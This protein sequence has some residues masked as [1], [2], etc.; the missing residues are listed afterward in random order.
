LRAGTSNSALIVTKGEIGGRL[1]FGAAASEVPKLSSPVHSSL[2]RPDR[3][4]RETDIML[5]ARS[6]TGG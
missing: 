2:R 6:S 4:V 5:A 3:A 1:V